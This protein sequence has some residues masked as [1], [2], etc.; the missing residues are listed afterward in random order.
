MKWG[1]FLKKTVKIIDGIIASLAAALFLLVSVLDTSLPDRINIYSNDNIKY[2]SFISLESSNEAKA[3]DSS[4]NSTSNGEMLLLGIIPIKEVDITKIDERYV[5]SGGNSFGIKIFTDGVMVV[6]MSDVDTNNGEQNPAKEAGLKIGDIIT[7]INGTKVTSNDE[8]AHI[9]SSSDGK[10]VTLNVVRN[11]KKIK[12][13][14]VPAFSVSQNEYKAGI[15]VRDSTAGI[16]TM[17]FY[18]PVTKQF[19]GLGHAVCD[20]DTGVLLPVGSGEIVESEIFSINK[21]SKGTAGELCGTFTGNRLG[22]LNNNCECGIFGT[23]D[24]VNADSGLIK[25]ALPQEVSTGKAEILTTL[26]DTGIQRFECEIE[27]IDRSDGIVTNM[28]IKIT[29]K[30]LLER[31]GGIVQGMSGS[32]IIQNGMLVGAVTHVFVND[33][34]RGYGVFADTMFDEMQQNAEE[35]KEAS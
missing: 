29:D 7:D 26:D 9:I 35:L 8:V 21:S 15:W 30:E 18:S 25:I 4:G 19:A 14:F 11:E 24:N 3:A 16:G 20:V 27:K 34:E 22:T 23:L 10:Q 12:I 1:D 32:P 17:T 31:T 13:E 33:P 2:S 6:G 28:V 5:I